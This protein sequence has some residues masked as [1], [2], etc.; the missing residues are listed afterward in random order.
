MARNLAMI[1]P[2]SSCC[3]FSRDAMRPQPD[4]QESHRSPNAW[5]LSPLSPHRDAI[6][7][8]RDVAHQHRKVKRGGALYRAGESFRSIFAVRFGSFKSYL[9]TE[10]GRS[11]ITGFQMVD[12]LL[13]WDGI[14]TQVHGL[15]AVAHEDSDVCVFPFSQLE[16]TSSDAQAV[17]PHIASVM[18]RE[19]TRDHEI[20]ILLGTMC[21]A[22]R[23]ATFLLNLSQ[24]FRA[25]GY[26]GKEFNLRM[27]REE[28][29]SYLGLKL[30]T[31]S[32]IMSRL[33]ED[34]LIATRDRYVHIMDEAGLSKRAGRTVFA[35]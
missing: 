5:A 8:I 12:D 15:S 17:N 18:S 14:D 34:G 26:S 22:E 4:D 31:V 29:G 3:A 6:G 27:T 9:S 35:S 25:C 33:Q 32:R 28:I 11:Q 19:I 7:N 23:V 30:E 21:A 16:M 13:G 24:R 1:H 20:I 10:D 2:A